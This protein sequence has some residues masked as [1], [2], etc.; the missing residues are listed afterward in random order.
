LKAFLETREEKFL[1]QQSRGFSFALHLHPQLELLLVRSGELTVYIRNQAKT[2]TA[3][4]L[5]VIFPNQI[6]SY[7]AADLSESHITMVISDLAYTGGYIDTLMNHHPVNPFICA[8][9]LHPNIHYAIEEMAKEHKTARDSSVYAPLIQLVFARVLPELTLRRNRSSDYQ[10][11]TW[12]I[13]HYV[14]EHF[15]QPL[16]LETLAREIGVNKYHLSHL[17]SEKIGQNFRSYL[18]GIRLSYA[19]SMLSETNRSVSDIAEESGFESQRTFFRVFQKKYGTTPLKYRRS[20]QQ[21]LR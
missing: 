4:S 6:H 13:V 1:A 7:D 8:K 5:A 15:S 12:K 21:E 11:L 14:N 10:E 18:S 16:T 3:G 20:K 9:Q 17:F 19:C 2:L